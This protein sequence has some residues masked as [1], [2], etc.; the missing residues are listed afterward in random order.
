[1]TCAPFISHTAVLPP[2]SRQAMSLLPLALKSWEL[3]V[4]SA[5][6]P[7]L[8]E[9]NSVNHSA[10]SG[11]VVMP[12]AKVRGVGIGNS[13]ITPA[14]VMRPILPGTDSLAKTSVY[15]SAPSGPVVIN[16]GTLG[17]VGIVNSVIT[18]AVVMRPT[19]PVFN[20]VNHSAPSGPVVMTSVKLSVNHSAPSGPVVM[21]TGPLPLVGSGNSVITPSVV[22][23][24]I[25]LPDCSVN[26]SA[27]SGPVVMPTALELVVGI[28]NS[29][30]IPAGVMRP[31]WLRSTNHSALSGPVVMAEGGPGVGN[32][33]EGSARA[34]SARPA[35]THSEMVAAGS[36]RR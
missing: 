2:L 21:P 19:L 31:I 16:W 10:P 4:V 6:R 22:M 8:P 13:V 28:G 29:L 17:V 33:V 25:L 24:P 3:T 1:M 18:P 7:I 9:V 11:P 26:H 20:S 35:T 36:K 34:G 23:R 30:T 15:H 27:P 5:K 32:S 12:S 14:V